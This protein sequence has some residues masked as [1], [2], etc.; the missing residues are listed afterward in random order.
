[1]LAIEGGPRII[2][3]AD[4]E[5][6]VVLNMPA[7]VGMRRNPMTGRNARDQYPTKHFPFGRRHQVMHNRLQPWQ[8][9]PRWIPDR[10]MRVIEG[11]VVASLFKLFHIVVAHPNIGHAAVWRAWGR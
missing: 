6:V 11:S 1:M 9:I 2:L 3:N 8:G 4:V 10:H 7:I 5:L